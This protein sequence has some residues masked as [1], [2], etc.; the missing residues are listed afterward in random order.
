MTTLAAMVASVLFPAAG[1]VA[2]AQGYKLPRSQA[3]ITASASS[4][5]ASTQSPSEARS[6]TDRVQIELLPDETAV[7]PGDTV[8]IALKQTIKPG[9]HTYWINPGDSGEPTHIDW[10][11]PADAS[12]GPIQWPLPK[13]IPI[14][15]LMN[16]GYSDEVILLSDLTVPPSATEQTFDISANVSWLVCEEICVPEAASVRLSLPIVDKTLSTPPSSHAGLIADM[17]EKLP[18]P[19]PWPAQYS[20]SDGADSGLTLRVSDAQDKIPA[21]AEAYFF[22]LQWGELAHAAPQKVA[23]KD[24]DLYLQTS[25]GDAFGAEPPGSINGVLAVTAGNGERRGYQI[26]AAYSDVAF[27]APEMPAPQLADTTG[28]LSIWVAL[29]FAFLGGLILNL[30][31]CVF[32]VL[33]LKAL[34]L[35]KNSDNA[36]MRRLKGFT[37]FG[38]VLASFAVIAGAL[39]ALRAGGSVIG[40]GMQFQ[41]PG[42]VLVMMA[43]FLALGLNMSGVYCF[44][45]SV[46]N[47]GD[48][49]T[50]RSGL[51][52]DFFTGVLATV[53]ATPCTAPFM[54][55]AMG[56][57]FAQPAPV[58]IA[59][60][61]ALGVG[62][63]LPILVLS[64][65]PTFA[66]ILPK[67]GNWM[68]TFRQV[69]AFPL[70]ATVAW[71]LWVLSIQL[72][73]DG[74]ILGG[75]T[76]VAVGFAAWLY[77]RS[78]HASSAGSWT[79]IGVAVLAIGLGTWAVTGGVSDPE[80][81]IVA[82]SRGSGDGPK[83]ESFSRARLNDLLARQR[84]VF[85]NLTAAW[86]ITCKVNEQVALSSEAFEDALKERGITYLVGDWTNGDPE[87][88]AL[89]S[90][91]G[92]VGV[93]LYLLYTGQ[94][95]VAPE[96]FPQILTHNMIVDAFA[97][98][99]PIRSRTAQ[100]L[101]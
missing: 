70:Y 9:W 58:V 98:I 5:S 83:S 25:R 22:P 65:S 96:V 35:A 45:S 77:G 55:A 80:R 81:R 87:I 51:S 89:L 26:S 4:P 34:S 71:L 63:G 92:R 40:W 94:P 17:R 49:L 48:N 24:G 10:Q 101:N 19:T 41:S 13:A 88:T 97:E 69:M 61:L 46:C 79:A 62:F 52:G 20:V 66:R 53:V 27:A 2:F 91:Q 50:R 32:P 74:V 6:G 86:C 64:L 78:Y 36:P 90:E 47:V 68:E 31:P 85:V 60:L 3:P 1:N 75:L 59:V 72:G 67:P 84:P 28:G 44:G 56:Y 16:Y 14:G 42:F 21:N 8:T 76:L 30:M 29:G 73:S 37:Y 95:G 18:Q 57:A 93:P 38:G 54:G 100:T 33:S 11:L 82:Q 15:P 7:S 39:L 43:L 12:A 23:F 99:P